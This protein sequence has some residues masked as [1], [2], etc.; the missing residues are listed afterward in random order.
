MRPAILRS[1]TTLLLALGRSRLR[2]GAVAAVVA[3]ACALGL[4]LMRST[5]F[6]RET[7]IAL[8]SG[9]WLGLL[10][11]LAVGYYGWRES[12]ARAPQRT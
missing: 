11:M 9:Q 8:S 2:L 1:L 6:A 12:R 4:W 5:A 3:A 7:A 10:T